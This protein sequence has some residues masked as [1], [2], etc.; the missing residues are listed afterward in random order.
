MSSSD[1]LQIASRTGKGKAE[2]LFRA[3]ISAFSALTRPSKREMARLEDLLDEA[4]AISVE[5]AASVYE[6]L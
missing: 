3:A 4:I 1:F 5:T 6:C 2:R